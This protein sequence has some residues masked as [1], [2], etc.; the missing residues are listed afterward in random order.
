MP[1]IFKVPISGNDVFT[2]LLVHSNTTNGDTVAIDSSSIGHSLTMT[3]GAAHSTTRAKFGATSIRIGGGTQYVFSADSTDWTLGTNDFAVDCWINFNNILNGNMFASHFD[4]GSPT[5]DK[6]WLFGYDNVSNY[7]QF[8]YTQDG[9]TNVVVTTSAGSFFPTPNTWYHMAV[10]RDGANLRMF[11]DG[12][13][14]GS[15]FNIGIDSIYNSTSDFRLGT[16]FVS[17]TAYSPNTLDGY[18]DEFRFSVGVPRYTGN[19]IPPS[20]PYGP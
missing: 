16:I 12:V 20:A 5:N 19:F 10:S 15:T 6:A 13:Q 11:V 1:F 7:L 14:L 3:G 4:G 8:T 18:I 9:T 2:K 17:G